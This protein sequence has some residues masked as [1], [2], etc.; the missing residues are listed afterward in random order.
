MKNKLQKRESLLG[1]LFLIPSLIAF[2]VF[3]VYPMADTIYLSFFDWNL[4]K[5]TKTFVGLSNYVRLFTD[6][7]TLKILKNTML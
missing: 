1:Y 3:M 5:P 6:P 2:A 7:N 4:V